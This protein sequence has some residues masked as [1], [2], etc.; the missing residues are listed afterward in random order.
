MES[1]VP[2]IFC[3]Y[4]NILNSIEKPFYVMEVIKR[5]RNNPFIYLFLCQFYLLFSV[6]AQL[7]NHIDKKCKH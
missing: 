2:S 4:W 1:E 7:R 3:G 6:Y 5:L